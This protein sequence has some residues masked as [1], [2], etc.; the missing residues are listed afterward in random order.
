MLG[1]PDHWGTEI[2]GLIFDMDGV[3]LLSRNCHRQA[4]E[5]VLAR[6]GIS[7]FSYDRFAGQRTADVFRA[8]FQEA[9]RQVSEETI[10][11]SAQWKSARARELLAAQ[12]PVAPD[13]VPVLQQLSDKYLLALASSGSRDS[14]R[15]F[16]DRT[17]LHGTF[18]SVISGDDVLRAKPDPEIFQS[19]IAAL[20]LTASSCA[21]VEDSVAGVQAARSAGARA[22]GFGS[23]GSGTD[24][25]GTQDDGLSNAGAECVIHSLSELAVLLSAS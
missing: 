18:R 22:I 11:E 6:F 25:F 20:G 2:K 1:S 8:V 7:D 17:E 5:E 4:F 23:D 15:A 13:C 9:G 19:S 3:L 24:G 12:N 14:V 16:L 21:V 10:A